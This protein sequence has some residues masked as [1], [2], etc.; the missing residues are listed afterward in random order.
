[1]KRDLEFANSE[2]ERLRAKLVVDDDDMPA[3]LEELSKNVSI[4]KSGLFAI[5][6]A[7]RKNNRDHS[8]DIALATEQVVIT[9]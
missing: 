5:Q 9:N 6:P 3:L 8:A 7:S 4:D 2:I 1:M